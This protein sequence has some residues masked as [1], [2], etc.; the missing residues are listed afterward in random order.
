MRVGNPKSRSPTRTDVG[1]NVQVSVDPKHKLIVDQGVTNAVTDRD[2]LSHMAK[3]VKDLL[4]VD[5]L[6]VLADMGYPGLLE[7]ATMARRSRPACRLASPPTS[8]SP[9][10]GQ[11][12]AGTLRQR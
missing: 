4:G 8:Q 9:N 10:H 3:R 2:L 6:E 1:Y 12:Q 5:E 11:P 7:Q